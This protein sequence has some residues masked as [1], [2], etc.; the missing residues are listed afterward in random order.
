[1]RNF[2]TSHSAFY[3]SFIKK[4]VNEK[5]HLVRCNKL[6]K[7]VW[8]DTEE[9]KED[10]EQIMELNSV[11]NN[12]YEVRQYKVMELIILKFFDWYIMFPTAAHYT[13]YYLQAVLTPDEVKNKPEK[14][15]RP[16]SGLF[17]L[18][19]NRFLPPPAKVEQTVDDLV[20]DEGG[21][22]LDLPVNL[23]LRL[24][25]HYMQC[26]PPSQLAAAIIAASRLQVGL[27][28]W[29][30]ELEEMTHYTKEDIESLA[31]LLQSK[32]AFINCEKCAVKH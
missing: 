18:L 12:R 30:D 23:A 1:M 24:N 11:I 21:Q 17:R 31:T 28:S 14:C 8:H 3:G 6:Q 16:R 7:E 22:F 25:I 5:V 26:Y 29:S 27:A 19:D 15:C 32:T 2:M 10:F 20:L 13:H 9:Y 4:Q